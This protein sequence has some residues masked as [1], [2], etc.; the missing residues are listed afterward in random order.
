MRGTATA[1]KVRVAHGSV[2]R[3]LIGLCVLLVLHVRAAP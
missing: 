2:R 1:V 3:A